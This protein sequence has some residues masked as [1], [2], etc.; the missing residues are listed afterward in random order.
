MID[1]N[2]LPLREVDGMRIVR[3]QELLA[4]LAG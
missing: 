2:V 1:D 3:P 4:E